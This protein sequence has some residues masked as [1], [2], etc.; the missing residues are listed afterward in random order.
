M[1]TILGLAIGIGLSAACGFRVFV[2]LLGLSI[3]AQSGYITLAH[4]FQWIGTWPAMV[5]FA[6]ATVLEVGA[7]YIPWVDN[8][9]DALM[10]PAAIVAGT[11]TTASMAV[12]ISPF[13]KWSTAII[14]GGGI[15]ALVQGGTVAL[16][17]KST[18]AT[19][20]ITNPIIST[21]ELAGSTLLTICAIVLPVISIVVVVWIC[22]IIVTKMV[23]SPFVR[24]F[25][26]NKS[27]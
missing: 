8:V 15:S 26:S 12:D 2:P 16:R 5:A 21:V 24:R 20:G 6:T 10:T 9:M 17:T 13:I 25:F 23:K 27:R 1:E 3:A 22:S 11:I 4:G 19:G 18:G 7:Y 14:A